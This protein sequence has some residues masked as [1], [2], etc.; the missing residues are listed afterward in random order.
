MRL[1]GSARAVLVQ[2]L[3]GILSPSGGFLEIDTHRD[4]IRFTL[5]RVH[6]QRQPFG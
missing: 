2:G 3:I 1:I 4:L 6:S 5:H